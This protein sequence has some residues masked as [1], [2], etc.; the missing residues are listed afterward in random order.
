VHMGGTPAYAAVSQA[1][2]Q[3]RRRGHP[4]LSGVVNGVLRSLARKGGDLSR[5]PSLAQDPAGHLTHWGSH[6]RWLVHRWIRAH[7]VAGAAALVEASN[8]IP[9]TYLRPLT[10]SSGEA[11]SALAAAGIGAEPGPPGSGTVRLEPG[12]SPET[13]LGVVHGI[14]QDPA[15]SWVVAWCGDV[16]DLRV[17]DLCAAPGG[18]ALALAAAG[19]RVTAAD[20]SPRRLALVAE[21]A[22]RLGRSLPLVR[23]SAEAPPFVPAD[24]VLLDA[25]CSGTGT[26]ARHPDGRWRLSETDISTLSRVQ[27]GLMDGAARAVKPGGLLVYSTC[28]LEPEEN[29]RQVESFLRRHDDFIVEEGSSVPTEVVRDGFLQ[30]LPGPWNTDG[31]FAARLRRS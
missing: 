21:A 23:A 18:K 27:E 15:A 14:I 7:G 12:S 6:P 24:L 25:P 20:L 10:G 3:T 31:S 17:L 22:H 4:R 11:V 16:R 28:T 30:I 29:A 1:V 2:E 19:G 8:R 9:A 5:F 13:A 26:L